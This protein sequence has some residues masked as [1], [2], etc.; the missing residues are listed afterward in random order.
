MVGGIDLMEDTLGDV[1]TVDLETLARLRDQKMPCDED[2]WRRLETSGARPGR[3]SNHRAVAVGDAIYVY[4][5][6]IN[7]ENQEQSLFALD[8]NTAVWK[9]ILT[10]A[11]SPPFIFPRRT[12]LRA[13]MVT[14]W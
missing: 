12:D 11:R 10:K 3:V 7:N 4:G 13:G 5:G 9:Q 1:W 14:A 2:L 6:L 8:V